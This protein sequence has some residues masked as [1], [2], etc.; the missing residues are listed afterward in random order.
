M[1]LVPICLSATH[2]A[3]CT[4]CTAPVQMMRMGHASGRISATAAKSGAA[5]QGLNT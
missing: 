3:I 4:I 2:V 5:V 1:L